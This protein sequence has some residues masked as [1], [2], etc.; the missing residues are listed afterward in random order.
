MR[1]RLPRVMASPPC[2]TYSPFMLMFMADLVHP[3]LHEAEAHAV[4]R[5]VRLGFQADVA[6]R[7]LVEHLDDP[8]AGALLARL[9]VGPHGAL[10]RVEH[11]VSPVCV[12][13]EVT[14]RSARIAAISGGKHFV[15]G[16]YTCVM[17]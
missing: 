1:S 14:I 13:M 5:A 11:G 8:P 9:E 4:A 16:L 7:A 10:D 6:Q 12:A 17:E 15:A 2:T 3:E